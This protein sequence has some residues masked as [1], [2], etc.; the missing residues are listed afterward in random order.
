[1]SSSSSLPQS[2]QQA[3]VVSAASAAQQQQQQQQKQK[4]SSRPGPAP[5]QHSSSFSVPRSTSYKSNHSQA[6]FTSTQSAQRSG[7]GKGAGLPRSATMHPSMA[8]TGSGGINTFA[9]PATGANANANTA[10][11]QSGTP[12][13]KSIA[14]AMPERYAQ[15][16]PPP[17][18]QP[19]ASASAS[20]LSLSDTG[21]NSTPVSRVNTATVPITTTLSATSTTSAPTTTKV[22]KHH[23]NPFSSHL[24]RGAS[25]KEKEKEP[26]RAEQVSRPEVPPARQAKQQMPPFQSVP[27]PVQAQARGTVSDDESDDDLF[28]SYYTPPSAAASTSTLTRVQTNTSGTSTAIS[29]LLQQHPLTTTTAAPPASSTE[30]TVKDVANDADDDI[31]YS[32]QMYVK[33]LTSTVSA[34][35]ISGIEQTLEYFSWTDRE[36]SRGLE[37]QIISELQVVEN[38][39]VKALI[40]AGNE[41]GGVAVA[42]VTNKSEK[43][44]LDSVRTLLGRDIRATPGTAADNNTNGVMELVDALDIGITECL[45]LENKLR[46]YRVQ[47]RS[48]AEDLN[49]ITTTPTSTAGPPSRGAKQ[50]I[51][52]SVSNTYGMNGMLRI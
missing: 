37:K 20:S 45:D 41:G 27:A 34:Q 17:T 44:G 47:L 21:V 13:F 29:A 36:S 48:L 31:L 42:G 49:N 43:R 15:H 16:H 22:K 35:D 1:M 5:L 50:S 12:M 23:H 32:T 6:S 24:L 3:A 38:S 46:V 26:P 8:S 9:S 39:T 28:D 25:K 2:R 11:L 19:S 51:T 10:P 40:E 7:S 14:L 52:P 4:Q 33:Q 30:D 18:S